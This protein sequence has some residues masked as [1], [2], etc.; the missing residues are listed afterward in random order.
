MLKVVPF[1]TWNSHC[2][3]LHPISTTSNNQEQPIG[4]C[5]QV[6]PLATRGVQDPTTVVSPLSNQSS[7]SRLSN[8]LSIDSGSTNQLSNDSTNNDDLY[9]DDDSDACSND[10]QCEDCNSVQSSTSS[11]QS[12]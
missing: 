8:R 12:S 6:D 7:Y 3:P 5:V 1:F 11:T 2:P 9:D 10:G 4:L